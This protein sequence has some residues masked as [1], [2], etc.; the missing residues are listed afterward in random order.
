MGIF[1][2]PISCNISISED[3]DNSVEDEECAEVC[4]CVCVFLE[5]LERSP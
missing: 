2:T 1:T 3:V 4:V 5:S